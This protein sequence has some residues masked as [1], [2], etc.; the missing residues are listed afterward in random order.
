MLLSATV[1][2]LS[3]AIV[4]A[5]Q[6]LY[7]LKSTKKQRVSDPRTG[8]W[9]KE[10][11]ATLSTP[12]VVLD[13]YKISFANISFL[14]TLGMAGMADQ[15]VGMPFT[16]LVH[17]A[18]HQVLAEMIAEATQGENKNEI[19]KL[20]LLCSDGTTIPSHTSLSRMQQDHND[21]QALLQF[22]PVSTARPLSTNFESQ[23]NYH[24]IIDRL[25]EIVFQINAEGQL[26]FLNSSWEHAL[27]YK[28]QECLNKPLINY[29]H[30]EDKPAVESRLTSL[31]QGKRS[32]C[33]IEFRL[34]ARNGNSQWSELRGKTTSVSENERTSVV[35]TISDI[36]RVKE[37]QANV[38]AHRRAMSTLLN[39]IPGMVYRGRNDRFWSFEFVSD[40]CVE[41]T[42]YDPMELINNPVFSFNQIIHPE[43]RMSV[44]ESVQ[45]QIQHQEK[46]QLIYR[47]ITRN[48]EIKQVMEHGRGIFS[49]AGELLALEG[50][51]VEIPNENP[52]HTATLA[53]LHE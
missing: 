7:F 39:N 16:N 22:T 24:Q 37:V 29:I 1:A 47:I 3:G 53:N 30:P 26:I 20:R 23:F 28:I 48:G 45:Q 46:F 14:Q 41:V 25:E 13:G 43:D 8:T 51:I 19:Q 27:D 17:P 12:A 36:S 11:S 4:I 49:S 9:G 40:G 6:S 15:V 2:I 52:Q 44:W 38:N 18:D 5:A 35:G 50:F 10:V 21:N 33:L 32:H 42:G 31:T 34:I